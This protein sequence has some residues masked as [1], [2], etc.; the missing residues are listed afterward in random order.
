MKGICSFCAMNAINV[1]SMPPENA[2]AIFSSA[3]IEFVKSFES[4]LI[5]SCLFVI[6]LLLF[7]FFTCSV[8]VESS[9]FFII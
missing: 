6:I 9:F 2:I 7:S 8:K 3:F 4:C 1:E 5:I